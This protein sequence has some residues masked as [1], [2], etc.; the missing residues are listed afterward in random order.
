MPLC[1][2][3][4]D[5]QIV[6]W[7]FDEGGGHNKLTWRMDSVICYAGCS[8]IIFKEEIEQ[9]AEILYVII[10]Q[11]NLLCPGSSFNIIEHFFGFIVF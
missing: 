10:L 8:I 5:W 2:K 3:N 4:L 11:V 6:S 7:G 9:Q 1:Y